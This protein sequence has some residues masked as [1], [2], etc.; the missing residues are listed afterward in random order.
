MKTL[1]WKNSPE[2]VLKDGI[3]TLKK[4]K[5]LSRWSKDT[6]GHPAVENEN[7]LGYYA[8]H[9]D[10][11]LYSP[12]ADQNIVVVGAGNW[13]FALADLVATQLL[14]DK[15]YSN[16]SITIFDSRKKL[17]RHMGK[18]R[19]GPGTVPGAPPEKKHLCHP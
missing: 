15:A 12:T 8:T 3:K 6:L 2:Q 7:G 19:L 11:R 14:E 13:G 17:V 9:G 18:E 10:R 1:S 5:I 16:A 4:R